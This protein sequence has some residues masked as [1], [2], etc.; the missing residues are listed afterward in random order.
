[1]ETVE[2]FRGLPLRSAAA[3]GERE[4]GGLVTILGRKEIALYE[5]KRIVVYG[6]AG[7]NL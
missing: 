1:M 6:R 7:M 5:K 3:A 2:F 4:S